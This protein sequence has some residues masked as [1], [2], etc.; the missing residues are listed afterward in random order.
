[1]AYEDFTLLDLKYKFQINNQITHLFDSKNLVSI[2]ASHFLLQQ[3]EE[4]NELSIK[5][6]K[7]RSELI[8]TP[9]LMELRRMNDKFFTIYS[10]DNLIV[11]RANGLAGEC[12]FILAKETDSFS[13]NLPIISVVEAKRQN[14]EMGISQCAAQLYGASLFNEKYQNNIPKVYGC[15]T[16]AD[17]WKFMLLENNV[18]KIDRT[19][20]YKS[21]LG[22]ILA[23]FNQIIAY[24]RE[25]LG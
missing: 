1:M 8:I 4:A 11:D 12:D 20:Y 5:S 9:I 7:A 22:K 16:T 24:Y 3:L 23:V 6:E 15:V 10:G 13:I 2:E 19:T 17:A 18:V 25:L 14:I 21:D